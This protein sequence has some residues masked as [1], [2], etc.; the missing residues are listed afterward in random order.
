M[1]ECYIIFNPGGNMKVVK[2]EL[3]KAE[4]KKLKELQINGS[5]QMRERS[6]AILHCATGRKITWIAEALNRRHLTIRNWINAFRQNGISGLERAYSPGRPSYR[7]EQLQPRLDEYLSQSPR[8]YGWAEDLWAIK[9]INAQFEKD[10]G[11]KFGASTVERL[12]KDAGYSYRR[13]K[14]TMPDS[15]PSKEEK[16]A[17]IKEIADAVLELAETDDIEVVFLDESHFSNEPY[18]IRGWYKKG[19]PFS[20]PD[21]EKQS[22]LIHL[23]G[24]RAGE[25][26]FLL[27]EFTEK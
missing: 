19:Q 22:G 21:S 20:P 4:Q 8:N 1:D 11:R 27:E 25:K 16:L 5:N 15:A 26:V 12:L 7:K 17:R 24:L 23:W 10:F 18:V 6:L 9:T 13:A 14:K 2:L 3:S